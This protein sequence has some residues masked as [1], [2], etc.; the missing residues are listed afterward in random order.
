[1]LNQKIIAIAEALAVNTEV[2]IVDRGVSPVING[3]NRLLAGVIPMNSENYIQQLNEFSHTSEEY[4]SLMNEVGSVLAENMRVTFDQIRVYGRGVAQFVGDHIC[5]QDMYIDD[6]DRLGKNFL[7]GQLDLEFIRTDHP[8][9]SSLLFPTRVPNQSIAFT[10]ISINEVTKLKAARWDTSQIIEW[11]GIENQEINELL[12]SSNINLSDC[13]EAIFSPYW[14]AF[15][16]NDETKTID[17]T[18]PN[19]NQ[20]ESL[21]VQ[22]IILGKMMADEIPFEGLVSGSL[23]DYRSH[24]SLLFSAYSAALIKLKDMAKGFASAPIRIIEKG[25]AA[26]RPAAPVE[27]AKPYSRVRAKATVYFNKAGLELCVEN[28][29]TLGEIVAAY[30]HRKYVTLDPS[31]AYSYQ[32]DVQA[33]KHFLKDVAESVCEVA[34]NEAA[35]VYKNLLVGA[36]NEFVNTRPE[37]AETHGPEGL[38]SI[39]NSMLNDR[40]WGSE[41]AWARHKRGLNAADAIFD[42]GLPA[43]FL[44]RIGCKD[45]FVILDLTTRNGVEGETVVDKRVML[46]EAVINHF[47]AK[48]MRADK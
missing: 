26:V 35:V 7:M 23:E 25:E 32:S 21:F 13:L 22:Y 38:Q 44:R 9:F 27:G 6:L 37:L 36:I 43:E 5:K 42:C 39:I 41:I 45:A 4:K 12:M 8:F 11:L 1:M 2:D 31:I 24:V 19:L 46:H 10:Q 14:S 30:Y 29:V 15:E 47:V 3:A 20:A 34:R 16:I 18:K 17:Y 48:L 33:G 28:K 40:N